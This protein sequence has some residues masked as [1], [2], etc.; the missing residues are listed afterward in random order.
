MTRKTTS[1]KGKVKIVTVSLSPEAAAKLDKYCKSH[2]RP[3]SWVVDKLIRE[4]LR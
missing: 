3:K 1:P 4:K 2:E